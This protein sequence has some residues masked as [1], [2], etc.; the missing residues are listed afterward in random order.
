[1]T[2]PLASIIVLGWGGEPYITTC[3]KALRCQTYPALE[4]IVVDNGSPD[5]TAE[6]V[7]RDFPEVKLIRTGRN[8]GVAGGNNV[9]LRAAQGEVLVLINSDVEVSPD[10]LAWL[11]RATQSDP[12][13]GIVG[14]KLLYPDGTIQFAGG[15]IDRPRGCSYHLGWHESDRGQWD[16]FGDVDFVTGASLAITRRTL[17]QIGYEDEKFFPIDYEDPDMSYRARAAGFR[18]VLA[19]QA[20]AIHHESS[21]TGATS[22]SRMLSLY[23]GRLRFVCKHWSADQLL[24]EFLPAE[25]NFL[26][27]GPLLHSQLSRWAC[28]K[29]LRELDDLADWRERLGLENRI[30]SLVV[31]T[32]MLTQ[33]RQASLPGISPTLPESVVQ[34]L[35]TW[36]AVDDLITPLNGEALLASLYKLHWRVEPHQPIAWPNW[37]RGVWPKV[38]ALFQ[39]VTRRLLSWYIT[40][41][42]EE[43]NSV[44]AALMNVVELLAE[45]VVLLREQSRAI[46]LPSVRESDDYTAVVRD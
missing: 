3:L 1:M 7:E 16:H 31:L 23:A 6:I 43:Q 9:G 2:D 35:E 19:P 29:M 45:E 25:L 8:L 13:I 10:W 39:K 32:D 12:T 38:I 46:S 36:F 37:P 34:I 5:R 24:Q 15:R 30:E 20:V 22:L 40:P 14:A 26:H 18:V 21:T 27:T 11:V 17:D 33:L 28:L 4:V 42:V 41:I 44:N